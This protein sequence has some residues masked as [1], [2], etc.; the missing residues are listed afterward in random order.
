[1]PPAPIPM[2]A[3]QII[4]DLT[5]RIAAG[6]YKPGEQLPT[7]GTLERLYGVK[8]GTIARVMLV[9]RDRGVVVGVPGRGTFVPTSRG[10]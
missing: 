4:E 9:L 1:M 10:Q 8:H 3:A 2:S 7:Y 6:E 5:S